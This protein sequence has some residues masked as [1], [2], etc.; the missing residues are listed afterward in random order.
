MPL[1]DYKCRT[2]N[3]TAEEFRKI[4]SDSSKPE[5][6]P[7]CTAQT[8]ERLPSLVHT[9]LKEFH[10][11]I[12]MYSIALDSDDEIR[13][14]MRKAPDVQVCTDPNSDMYGIPVAR[15]R[16]QKLQA[17]KAMNYEEVNSERVRR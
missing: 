8:Y 1:Y 14:F 5:V 17:L 3:H 10:T 9:D 2:C 11:P 12:E 13:E 6:C 15:N 7:E 4:T 16:H